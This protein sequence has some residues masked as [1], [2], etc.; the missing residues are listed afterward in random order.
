MSHDAN[1]TK[2]NTVNLA[3]IRDFVRNMKHEGY[4]NLESS[5][6]S[7]LLWSQHELPGVQRIILWPIGLPKMEQNTVMIREN[8]LEVL[9]TFGDHFQKAMS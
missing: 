9:Y 4:T 2:I 3:L 7:A 5:T 6:S 8:I 1:N